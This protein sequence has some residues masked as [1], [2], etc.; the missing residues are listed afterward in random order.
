[1]FLIVAVAVTLTES[2]VLATS[3]YLHRGLAHRS[4]A[5]L[6]GAASGANWT[7]VPW[8]RPSPATTLGAGH[9][10]AER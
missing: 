6:P 4:L 8:S 5:T 10:G 7:K 9:S 2:A 1:M 3:I